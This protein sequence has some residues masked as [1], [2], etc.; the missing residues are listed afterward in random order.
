MSGYFPESG[1]SS[2]FPLTPETPSQQRR[3]KSATYNQSPRLSKISKNSPGAS[4][5]RSATVR[6]AAET[7]VRTSSRLGIPEPNST[8]GLRE[9]RQLGELNVGII[10]PSRSIQALPDIRGKENHQS[11]ATLGGS[12]TSIGLRARMMAKWN[13]T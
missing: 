1:A 8:Q 6:I 12:T 10:P 2:S 5:T 4:A 11:P 3:S 13:R 9:R 7:P